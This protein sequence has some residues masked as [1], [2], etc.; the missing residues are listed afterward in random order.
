M[1][2]IVNGKEVEP[3]KKVKLYNHMPERDLIALMRKLQED[4]KNEQL[5]G[6]QG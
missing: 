3:V 6:N 5:S 1:K 4:R 2:L